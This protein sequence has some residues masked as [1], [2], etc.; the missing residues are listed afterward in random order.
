MKKLIILTITCIALLSA[1]N[2]K[3]TKDTNDATDLSE[4]PKSDTLKIDFKPHWDMLLILTIMPDSITTNW[5]WTKQDRIDFRDSIQQHNYYVDTTLDNGIITK[6]SNDY[7]KSQ[8]AKG[9][10]ELATYRIEDGHYVILTKES[11]K[12]KQYFTAYELF[13]PG[14]AIMPETEIVGDYRRHLLKDTTKM[15]CFKLLDKNSK[16]EYDITEPR[17]LHI[18]LKNV[19][20]EQG[21]ECLNGNSITLKFD[22]HVRP[23]VVEGI[24]WADE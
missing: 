6:F 22:E 19:S 9:T 24:K 11:T 3:G 20:K 14:A 4:L 18:R 5:K 1:C 12:D 10:F 17:K 21:G 7:I 2:T 13:R 23:F 16:F 15:A 8:T